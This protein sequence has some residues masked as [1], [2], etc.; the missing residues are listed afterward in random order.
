MDKYL[1]T[2]RLE[3]EVEAYDESDAQEIIEDTFGVGE[4][5]GVDIT[6]L[7]IGKN[8]TKRSI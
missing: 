7:T 1:Y 6:K 8:V 5:G 2:I 3:V 4:D